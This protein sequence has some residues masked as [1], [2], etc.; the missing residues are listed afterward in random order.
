MPSLRDVDA[1]TLPPT[2]LYIDGSIGFGGSSKSLALALAGLPEV[3]QLM[4]T[5][6]QPAILDEL[7]EP[8]PTWRFRRWVNYRNRGR[9]SDGLES[10]RTPKLVRAIAMKAY[11]AL[12]MLCTGINTLRLFWIIR[13]HRVDLVH[14]NNGYHPPEG[15]LAARLAQVPLVGHMRGMPTPP[16]KSSTLRTVAEAACTIVVSDAVGASLRTALPGARIVTIYDPVELDRVEAALPE[17][18]RMRKELR[19]TDDEILVGLFGRVVPWKGQLEFVEACIAAL[20]HNPKIVAVIVGSVSD[21]SAG[22]MREVE[23]AIDRSGFR[24]RFRLTGYRTDVE[25][26]YAAMDIVVHASTSPEPFGMVIP[27]AMA[28][29]KPVIATA[30]GGPREIVTEGVDGLLVEPGDV[31]QMRDAILRLAADP[32]ER[33]ELGSRGRATVAERFTVERHVAEIRRVYREALPE[34]TSDR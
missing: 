24:D 20:K 33:K 23:Q 25:A 28:A 5:A 31:G 8:M 10:T 19:A 27:E 9:L 21:G 1:Q 3:R 4:V 11:S 12:D 17:R 29:G 2:V 34:S 13:R 7:F 6:Q 18:E 26:M 14:L 16:F 15:F 30:A 32:N 22:Y